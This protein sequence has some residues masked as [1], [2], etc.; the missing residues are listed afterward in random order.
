MNK[1]D[2]IALQRLLAGVLKAL[3]ILRFCVI[4]FARHIEKKHNL[5]PI[6]T[7]SE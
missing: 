7:K 4:T 3:E 6:S 2:A 5:L 1:D